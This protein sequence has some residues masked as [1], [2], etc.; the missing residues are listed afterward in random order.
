[1]VLQ[2]KYCGFE[3]ITWPTLSNSNRTSECDPLLK[4][5][6]AVSSKNRPHEERKQKE[7]HTIKRHGVTEDGRFSYILGL[8]IG[9]NRNLILEDLFK[10]GSPGTTDGRGSCSVDR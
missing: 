9:F 5:L 3:V 8:C 4:Q 1:M 2:S 10:A 6:N 7:T